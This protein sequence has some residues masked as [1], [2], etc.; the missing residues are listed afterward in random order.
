LGGVVERE[1]RE[2]RSR[3]EEERRGVSA[4]VKVSGTERN[5]ILFS[6]FL[7]SSHFAPLPSPTSPNLRDSWYRPVIAMKALTVSRL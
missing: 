4:H 7:H 1:R 6:F 2:Q 3:R 5:K